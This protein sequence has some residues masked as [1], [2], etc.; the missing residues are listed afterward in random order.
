VVELALHWGSGVP[1][2][3]KMMMYFDRAISAGE[4]ATISSEIIW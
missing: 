3:K 1:S 2:E 4:L